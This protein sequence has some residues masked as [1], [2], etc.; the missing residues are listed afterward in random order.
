MYN[1]D[2]AIIDKLAAFIESRNGL[3]TKDVLSEKVAGEFDLTKDR[4]VYYNESF[5]IRFSYSKFN[6]DRISNTVLSLSALQKYDARPFLVCIVTPRANYL[7]LANTTLL[8]KISHSS[9]ELAVDNIRGSFNGSDILREILGI[10][11]TP[12]NFKILFEI[13]EGFSFEDN[14]IRLVNA[15]NEISGSGK[16]YSPNEE[17]IMTIRD[18]PNRAAQFLSSEYY[19][20][21]KS[22][23][24]RRTEK[25][26]S[27]IIIASLIDNVNVRGRV[28]EY[29]IADDD[30]NLK[31]HIIK[32]MKGSEALPQFKTDD[33]L[34]DYHKQYDDFNVETDIKTKV[35]YLGSN[36]KAYNIDKLLR[37]LAN[38]KSVYM[39]FLVGITGEDDLKMELVSIFQDQIRRGTRVFHHW[40]GRNSRGVAQF[41]GGT[42]GA[43]ILNPDFAI[44]RT[45]SRDMLSAWIG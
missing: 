5:A 34:G 22:D 42:L 2:S 24:V 29:L 13:H 45:D 41:D 6:T 4:K 8:S 43:A 32:A 30:E 16:D 44:N 31:S 40:A 23:L 27:E 9:I 19:M 3:D 7:K 18:A 20:D 21:L 26:K 39:V 36:P 11:N 10:A 37:F 25:Y 38:E 1:Y 33:E 15:T 14:L 28:I 12:G 35:L 17:E